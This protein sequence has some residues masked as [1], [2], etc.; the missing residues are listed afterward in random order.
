VRFQKA[1]AAV[2]AGEPILRVALEHGYADQSHMTRVFRSL[3]SVTPRVLAL[4]GARAGRDLIRAGL[5]GR[6]FLLDLH[7]GDSPALEPPQ[8]H[9]AHDADDTA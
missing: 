2:A 9:E 1:A 4:D 8:A 3:A 7:D 6:V 5:A